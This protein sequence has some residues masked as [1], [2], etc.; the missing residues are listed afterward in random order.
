MIDEAEI[1]EMPEAATN[2]NLAQLPA[3]QARPE[4]PSI[5]ARYLASE[6]EGAIKTLS[7]TLDLIAEAVQRAHSD[8]DDGISGAS[9]AEKVSGSKIPDQAVGERAVNRI[10]DKDGNPRATPPDLV[11]SNARQLADSLFSARQAA[12]SAFLAAHRLIRMDAK[13][14]ANEIGDTPS[15]CICCGRIVWNTVTDRR[16]AERCY[17][18][19]DWWREHGRTDCAQEVHDRREVL[20]SKK[21]PATTEP[22]SATS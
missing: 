16:R 5:S 10:E 7:R 19:W 11:R 14:V 8:C 15:N 20:R 3:P 9:D 4:Q 2:H 13:K 22:Q 1:R 18:C 21:Q 12:D 6:A 17:A